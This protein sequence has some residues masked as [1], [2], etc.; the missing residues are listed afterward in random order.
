MKNK[1]Y[2]HTDGSCNGNPGPGG[3]AAILTIPNVNGS[4]KREISGYSNYTTNSRMEM[5]AIIEGL[6]V[7]SAP[8]A[9]I[10]IITDSKFIVNAINKGQIKKW[11]SNN[12]LK[13]NKEPIANKD[14]WQQLIALTNLFQVKFTWVKS[15]AYNAGNCRADELARAA[16][17]KT[18]PTKQ[19]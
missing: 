12:W 10:E 8:G 4:Q 13:G 15:H 11:I 1:I 17:I 3:W 19:K 9:E 18:K 2:I 14:L 16:C 5:T 6:A 7:I